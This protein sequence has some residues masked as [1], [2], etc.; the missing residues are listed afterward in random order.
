L[1]IDPIHADTVRLIYRLALNGDGD[2]GPMGSS[3]SPL[4]S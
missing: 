2:S 4:L 3:R 1:G